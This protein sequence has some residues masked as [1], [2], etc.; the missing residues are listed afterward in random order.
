[1]SGAQPKKS[2]PLLAAAAALDQELR[3]YDELAGEAKHLRVNTEKG[4][5]RAIRIVQESARV[6]EGIQEKLRALVAQIE[7]TRGRQVESLNVLLE[8]ARTVQARAESHDV[9]MRRFGALGESARHL[10]DLVGVLAA[11]RS[12]GATETE[13]LAGLTEIQTQ[14]AAV[15]AEAEALTQR[16]TEEDWPDVA[17]QADGVRQQVVA[18]RNKLALAHRSLAT[19]SPS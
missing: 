17:R 19:S 10:N 4:M 1:M 6:N 11:K 7:E 2:S 9:L 13:L 8:A 18:A 16:A 5:Q 12:Q 15:A 14:M 3:A